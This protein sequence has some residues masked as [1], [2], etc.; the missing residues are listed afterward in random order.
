MPG[1]DVEGTLLDLGQLDDR[2]TVAVAVGSSGPYNFIIDTGAERTV[3]S[4]ELAGQLGLAAGA[5][6]RSLR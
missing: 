2:L 1:S 3:V 6:V 5:P 4:R